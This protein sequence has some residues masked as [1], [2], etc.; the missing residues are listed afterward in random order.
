MNER[1]IVLLLYLFFFFNVFDML[2]VFN[3]VDR[4][5]MVIVVVID[6]FKF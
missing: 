4:K 6:L 1:F 2:N 5:E 3:G